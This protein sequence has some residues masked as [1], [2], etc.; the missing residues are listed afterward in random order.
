MSLR[1]GVTLWKA[2]G[3]ELCALFWASGLT[4]CLRSAVVQVGVP[5][6]VSGFTG[7]G[8]PHI[9]VHCPPGQLRV[10]SR[11]LCNA[12]KCVLLNPRG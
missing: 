10:V 12:P 6:R 1:L 4:G 9:A 3:A 11:K 8:G 2:A 7:E 5:G